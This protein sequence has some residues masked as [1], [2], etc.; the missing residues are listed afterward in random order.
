M[1]DKESYLLE[2][3]KKRYCYI[4]Q[5]FVKYITKCK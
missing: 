4:I 2:Y 1:R 5:K 3:L